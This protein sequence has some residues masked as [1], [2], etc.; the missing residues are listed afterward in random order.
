MDWID[1]AQERRHVASSCEC[2]IELLGYLNFWK[3][4]D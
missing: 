4:F 1:L 2:A 3:F